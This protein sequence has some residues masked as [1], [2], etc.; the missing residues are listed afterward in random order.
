VIGFV[1]LALMTGGATAVAAPR[2]AAPDERAPRSKFGLGIVALVVAWLVLCATAIPL[3]AG[4]KLRASQSDAA[5]GDL[6]AA[7]KD[8]TQARDV[9]P[10]AFSPYEQAAL[11]QEQAGNFPAAR[12]WVEKAIDRDRD[13]WQLW[14]LAA[15]IQV[16]LGAVADAKRSLAR[17]KALNPRSCIWKPRGCEPSGP[18]KPSS[19]SGLAL[20][21]GKAEKTVRGTGRARVRV[22]FYDVAGHPDPQAIGATPPPGERFVAVKLGFENRGAKPVD[23]SAAVS[24]MDDRGGT[25]DPVSGPGLQPVLGRATIAPHV[26]IVGY[27]T[28]VIPAS[29]KVRTVDVGPLG[30]S[31]ATAEF[32]V[33]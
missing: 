25:H 3:L 31:G 24:I 15:R 16:K 22:V 14:L 7:L 5:R 13:N 27:T 17:A 29:A 21:R 8:A 32:S 30:A 6:P 11:V 28:F 18:S 23:T 4:V 9:E 19:P 1:C 20:P 12:S 10:W 26:G 2:P 33:S